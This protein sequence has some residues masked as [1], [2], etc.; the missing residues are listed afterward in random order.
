MVD[1][2]D[3]VLSWE[4]IG[5]FNIVLPFLLIFAISFAILKKI[6]LFGEEGQGANFIISCVLGL[7]FLQNQELIIKLN[8]FLPAASLALVVI[9]IFLL[10]LGTFMG[11]NHK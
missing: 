7:L 5:F 2:Y 3:L 10:M 9:V 1:F 4:S 8:N 11:E 6:K